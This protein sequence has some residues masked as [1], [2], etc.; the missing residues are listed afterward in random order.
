[1]HIP[2]WFYV[3]FSGESDLEKE[4]SKNEILQNNFTFGNMSELVLQ[5]FQ[6][7]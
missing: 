5:Y 3:L 2:K 6:V 1:M 4:F 7:L